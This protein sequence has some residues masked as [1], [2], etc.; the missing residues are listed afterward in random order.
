MLIY[1]NNLKSV[2]RR[3]FSFISNINFA[4]RCTQIQGEGA[5]LAPPYIEAFHKR[6]CVTPGINTGTA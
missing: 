3:K 5:L 4:A 2:E 1:F 6:R